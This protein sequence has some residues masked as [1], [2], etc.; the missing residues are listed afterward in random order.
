MIGGSGKVISK[1]ELKRTA[2]GVELITDPQLL[3]LDEPTSGLDSFKAVSIVKMMRNLARK[4]GKT[5]ITTIH[6]P[7]SES[8][9]MF[10]RLI[11]MCDGYI[12]YQGLAKYSSQYFK[13]IGW[14][15]PH[16]TNPADYF[17]TALSISYPKQKTDLKKIKALKKYYDQLLLDLN[18]VEPK[19][20][21]LPAPD[22]QSRL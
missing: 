18:A 5:I 9:A 10:D 21:K 4:R 17:M 19:K 13:S 2:I 3:L 20:L 7:S 6:Q 11:L 16:H 8:F 22:V 15:V 14:E 1:S 12:V